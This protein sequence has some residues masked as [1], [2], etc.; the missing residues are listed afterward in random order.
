VLGKSAIDVCS[1]TPVP[2]TK[3]FSAYGSLD[4]GRGGFGAG[5]AGGG[6]R[7]GGGRGAAGGGRG[8]AGAGAGA[9]GPPPGIATPAATAP[10]GGSGGRGAAGVYQHDAEIDVCL[11][12]IVG[13]AVNRPIYKILGG[14]KTRVMAYAS[15][16]HLPYVEDFG[17]TF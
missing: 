7:A 16:Q 15:S 1:L 3:R 10:A 12:D 5:P 9:A 14:T 8:A 11:W 17:P 4:S 13:K 6:G 2:N